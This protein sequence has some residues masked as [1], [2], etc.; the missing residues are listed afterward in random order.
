MYKHRFGIAIVA[1]TALLTPTIA[2]AEVEQ[3]ISVGN[4]R[5]ENRADGSS[6]IQMPGTQIENGSAGSIIRTPGTQIESGSG[7]SIIRTPS[8]QIDRT[9]VTI[10][11]A[12][13]AK[14]DRYTYR[15]QIR[16]NRARAYR[17]PTVVYTPPK[18][19]LPSQSQSRTETITGNGTIE[20]RT[21]CSNGSVV[22]SQQTTVTNNGGNSSS[23]TTVYSS[24]N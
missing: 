13:T 5:I 1:C 14:S 11:K 20:R 3:S 19:L 9:G 16:K 8:T 23:K 24:C 2:T 6:S 7:G 4:I 12:P 18:V 15:K 10:M 21:Q 22:S 17:Q